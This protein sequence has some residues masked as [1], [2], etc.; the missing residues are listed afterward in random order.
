MGGGGPGCIEGHA[1][2]RSPTACICGTAGT[3]APPPQDSLQPHQRPALWAFPL[4]I[5]LL[6]H[7]PHK[8]AGH[9]CIRALPAGGR[10][11]LAPHGG[12]HL[13]SCCP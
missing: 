12:R 13:Y 11:M 9:T 4:P 8:H 10:G 2:T 5:D 3:P 7:V 6:P 1:L